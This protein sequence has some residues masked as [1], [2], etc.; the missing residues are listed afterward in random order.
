M[1]R[2]KAAFRISSLFFLLAVF[3]FFSWQG[4][5]CAQAKSDGGPKY[6]F[7]FIGDGMAMPQIK[8]AEIYNGWRQTKTYTPVKFNFSRF[9]VVGTTTTQANDSFITGS[10]A[11][12]T[13]MA[14]G[15]KTN[16]R[17]ISI[18]PDGKKLETIAEL[19]K[20]KKDM[21]IA[22][23]STVD[24]N[25]ATPAVFYAHQKDR[26]ELHEIA[27]QMP[28]SGF[29][30]FAGGPLFYATKENGLNDG[31]P[32]GL[33]GGKDA[34]QKA[35]D[36]GYKVI[37]NK[38]DF[39]KLS[40]KDDKV[41]ATVADDFAVQINWQEAG[42]P[43]Y[44]DRRDENTLTLADCVRKGIEVM[45]DAK[46]GFFMM[47][48]CGR[49]DWASHANDV[50]TTLKEVIVLD[51][52]IEEALKFYKKHPKETLIVVTGDH[53]TG[54]LSIGF[55]DTEYKVY[56]DVLDLQKC[57]AEKFYE[58]FDKFVRDENAQGRKP[59]LENI[60]P[61]VTR[62]F[63]LKFVG[64]PKN[65]RMVVQAHELGDLQKAFDINI[66]PK[67]QRDTS[68]PGYKI[69]YGSNSYDPF[70]TAV[71]RLV[72][73]RAGLDFTTFQHTGLPTMVY[74]LGN[75]AERFRGELDN[76]DIFW[77]ISELCGVGDRPRR[78]GK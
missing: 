60:K 9:P 23:I 74:A 69:H 52:A 40:V 56:L 45:G 4:A 22:I 70:T 18:G 65:D 66:T 38:K 61:L 19:L 10:D 29:N 15:Y 67:K 73:R 49:L 47:A 6:V 39:E 2:K 8:A 46:N 41:I 55:A 24:I 68:A 72:N 26:G 35:V 27:M 59:S 48:E 7:L 43:Y 14:T 58:I 63:G 36:M 13:A 78:A 57:S 42:L 51:E 71:L 5:E 20:R 3:L 75:G 25:D 54:G 17:L 62:Y 64:D 33:P 77:N 37:N 11:A 1:N 21:Q 32:S 50:A 12:G 28:E 44:I 16:D 31:L 34:Y 30:F 76:T 53:E